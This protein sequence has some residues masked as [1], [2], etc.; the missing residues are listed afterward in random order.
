MFV[1]KGLERWSEMQVRSAY[2]SPVVADKYGSREEM[3]NGG[4][5]GP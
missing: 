4:T 5:K 1:E 2:S 3:E